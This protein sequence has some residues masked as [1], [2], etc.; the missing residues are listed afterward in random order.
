MVH[1]NGMVHVLSRAPFASVVVA[2]NYFWREERYAL[3]FRMTSE[4][5]TSASED[6]P[7]YALHYTWKQASL[8]AIF[9]VIL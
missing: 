1:G 8:G 4:A 6:S 9:I 7:S 5:I 2:R 3:L